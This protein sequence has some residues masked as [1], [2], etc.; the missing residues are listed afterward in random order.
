M[1]YSRI[2]SCV[3]VCPRLAVPSMKAFCYY[4]VIICKKVL[5]QHAFWSTPIQSKEVPM[6]DQ[7]SRL[8]PLAYEAIAAFC[9]AVL[10]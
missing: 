2:S 1:S 4:L 7:T 10:F 3:V 8:S 6:A 9:A 5:Q